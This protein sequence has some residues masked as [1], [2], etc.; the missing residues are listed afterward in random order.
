MQ[1]QKHTAWKKNRKFGDIMGG[2][3]RRRLTDR[4][5]NRKHNLTAPQSNEETPIF[6]V[7]NPSKDFYFPVTV[8]EVKTILSKL[9]VNHTSHLT[10]IWFQ[11]IK[12]TDYLDGKTFQGC[13]ICGSGV[14]LIV[15]YPFPIDNKMRLGKSKPTKRTLNYYCEYTN[16]IHEDKDGWYLQWNCE[17]IKKY[18][19][20]KLLLHEIAH[21]IDCFYKSYWSKATTEKKENWADNYAAVWANTVRETYYDIVI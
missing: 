15:L 7:D 8:D 16:D 19:L 20:E 17:K 4:I 10:H 14:Y 1:T 11:R 12:K 21:S 5:F 3:T 6:K 18:Y 2:R 9:P 13:F